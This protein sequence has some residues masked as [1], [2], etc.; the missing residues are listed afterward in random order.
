[1]L[2]ADPDG[3]Q[4]GAAKVVVIKAK[5]WAITA[6]IAALTAKTVA[7]TAKMGMIRRASGIL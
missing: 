1:M 2:N 3:N 4:E 7:K 5:K 6:K